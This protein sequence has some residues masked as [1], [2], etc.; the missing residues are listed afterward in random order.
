M[1]FSIKVSQPQKEN[2]TDSRSSENEGTEIV[3]KFT[4]VLAFNSSSSI[5]RPNLRLF[6]FSSFIKN[7]RFYNV[8]LL[9]F[10][11]L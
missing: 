9:A 4:F 6:Y 10:F 3:D 11:F 2:E 7:M 5:S 8:S 1:N